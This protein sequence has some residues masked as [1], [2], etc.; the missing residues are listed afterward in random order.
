[1][2]M[3]RFRKVP[4]AEAARWPAEIPTR[5]EVAQLLARH[6]GGDARGLTRIDRPGA[7]GGEHAWRGR[8]YVADGEQHRQFSDALYGGP[9]GAL[10]A[11]IAW[12]D[13][14][15]AQLPPK[16][17]RPERPW[18]VVRCAYERATGYLVY[19]DRRRF[20]S[21]NKWGGWGG[22]QEAA[23]AWLLSRYDGS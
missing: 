4:P 19:A 14:Q 23:E 9:A 6:A 13:A 22:A 12:R 2:S 8:V 5:A 16:P 11:A 20:F 7:L 10:V 15:R 3:P 17:P 21:V 1:M 18:R